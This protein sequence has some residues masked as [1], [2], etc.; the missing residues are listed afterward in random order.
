MRPLGAELPDWS[1]A[2]VWRVEYERRQ[3]YSLGL[4]LPGREAAA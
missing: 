3:L 1:E 2:R 4:P